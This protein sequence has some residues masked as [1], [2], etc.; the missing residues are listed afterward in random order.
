MII[1]NGKLLMYDI[2]EE[3]KKYLRKFD[4]RVSMKENRKFYGILIT[5]DNF[6]YYIPFTSKIN[7]RTSSKLT[8]NVKDTNNRIIS[9]LLLNNMIPVN[10]ND[11]IIVDIKNSEY[12]D[13][14][15]REIIYLRKEKVKEELLRKVDN[16][17]KVLE[18]PSNIDY[19]FFKKLCCDFRMLEDKCIKFSKKT[20]I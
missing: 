6:D 2:S 18:N 19:I 9:K 20:K 15:N 13:Y 17:F 5:K 12:K 16:I 1:K 14:F 10:E 7:K 11:A 4:N 3:Y 8:I